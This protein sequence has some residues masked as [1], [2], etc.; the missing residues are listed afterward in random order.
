M[1][2]RLR[3]ILVLVT[4][5]LLFLG[6]GLFAMWDRKVLLLVVEAVFVTSLVISLRLSLRGLEPL[7]RLRDAA[8]AIRE[9]DHTTRYR[10]SGHRDV[11]TLVDV[12]NRMTD[13][14]R[15]QRVR[16]QEQEQILQRIEE[17]SPTAMIVLDH[18]GRIDRL[19]PAARRLVDLAPG[20]TLDEG[21]DEIAPRLHAMEN[22]DESVFPLGGRRRLRARRLTIIDRGFP[23]SFF[24]VDELTDALRRSEKAAYEKLIRMMA[25]EVNNTVGSVNSLL[26]SVR[27][28][29]A[30]E[31][32]LKRA[33][34]ALDVAIR[35]GDSMNDFMRS[36][37]AVVRVAPPS[38]TEERPE[39]LLADLHRL[40]AA[41]LEERRIAWR[42]STEDSEPTVHV[43]RAQLEHALTNVV[44]NAIES[45]DT[46]GTL[47]IRSKNSATHWTLEILDD[48][49]G[50]DSEAADQL[51]T[52]F[53][54]TK[55]NGQ[56]VGLMLV[57]EILLG[58][59]ADFGLRPTAAGA[60]FWMRIPRKL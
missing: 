59:E 37:A 42:V 6:L 8:D 58:H 48:G 32:S 55:T 53:F 28:M 44:R 15:D 1:S 29:T 9:G 12:Y 52:A 57:Q 20:R 51:F 16:T 56:G 36:L 35:R 50:I 13:A 5:H 24:L 31:P 19:N 18:D 14:L 22:G 41:E 38:R 26:D 46:D 39:E 10:R 60:A 25:H 17:S 3:L 47:E 43:D 11:D 34:D 21:D 40:F 2:L 7:A 54:T 33:A 27:S 4:T 30:H 49:A 45:I 23:R